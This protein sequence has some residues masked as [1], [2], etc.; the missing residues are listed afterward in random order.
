MVGR[1]S[2]TTLE[3]ASKDSESVLSPVYLQRHSRHTL[4]KLIAPF[5]RS[6]LSAEALCTGFVLRKAAPEVKADTVETAPAAERRKN[7]EVFMVV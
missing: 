1:Y 4:S 6:T 7:W 5:A 3:I 2:S